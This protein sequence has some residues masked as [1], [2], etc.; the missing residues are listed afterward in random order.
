MIH[1]AEKRI[2]ISSLYI[3]SARSELV[4]HFFISVRL[5]LIY[6]IDND[7]PRSAPRETLITI[8]F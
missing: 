8:V 7:S 1:R 4:P 6:V 2:F 5:V 3:G